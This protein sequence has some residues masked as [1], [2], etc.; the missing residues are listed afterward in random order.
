[1]G[2]RIENLEWNDT[3]LSKPD[4]G[5]PCLIIRQST[6]GSPPVLQCRTASYFPEKDAFLYLD[7][8]VPIPSKDVV[9][10]LSLKELYGN[11]QRH[12]KPSS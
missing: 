12:G 1:M 7:W 8:D 4:P 11:A 9:F 2:M 10:W 5:I 3:T 6:D